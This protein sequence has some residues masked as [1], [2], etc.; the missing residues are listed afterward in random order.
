[1]TYMHRMTYVHRTTCMTL[2]SGG[3][4]VCPVRHAAHVG[5]GMTNEHVEVTRDKHVCL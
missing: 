1:M 5:S 3:V 2:P 4:M